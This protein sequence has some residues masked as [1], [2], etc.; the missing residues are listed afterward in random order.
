MMERVARALMLLDDIVLKVTLF[1]CCC[2]WLAGL[3]ASAGVK[4]RAH[5]QVRVLADRVPA[6]LAPLLND[7]TD[8]A[9]FALGA[10]FI[11]YGAEMLELMGTETAASIPVAW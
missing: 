4:L 5:P 1:L 8:C 9:I 10:V 11:V 6:V 7:L 2:L 3:G